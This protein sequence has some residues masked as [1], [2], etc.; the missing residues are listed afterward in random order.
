[1]TPKETELIAKRDAL[2]AA[3]TAFE[4]DANEANEKA[5]IDLTA[6]VERLVDAVEREKLAAA[7][8][9]LKE[10]EVNAPTLNLKKQA[11]FS[12]QKFLLALS[13]PTAR[14]DAGYEFEMSQEAARLSGKST[15]VPVIPWGAIT[16]KAQDTITAPVGGSDLGMSLAQPVSHDDLFTIATTASFLASA[17]G[18]LGVPIYNAPKGEFRVP[19]MVQP[20]VPA[21][22]A[23]DAAVPDSSAR[24]DALEMKPHTLGAICQIN[25]SALID[26]AP[27][28]INVIQDAIWAAVLNALDQALLGA[29]TP[30]ADQPDGLYALLQG[31][32]GD[33]GAFAAPIDLLAA[34]AYVADWN[35]GEPQAMI[36]SNRLQVWARTTAMSASLTATPVLASADDV[37]MKG[38]N[39]VWNGRMSAFDSAGTPA[40]T[41]PAKNNHAMFGPFSTHAMTV[42]FGGGVELQVN[43]F[44][45]SVYGKGAILVRCMTDADILIR[46]AG[47]FGMGFVAA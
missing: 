45:D 10:I 33:F 18:A 2:V 4:A 9:S 41:P 3:T 13:D 30:D 34:L 16:T 1:M 40:P 6:E 22:V 19:R 11:P 14:V 21:W 42:L 36:A 26:T 39:Q 29:P 20:I 7:A 28:M 23:R 44:A 15:S 32:A 43:P 31:T 24:F 17:A 47:R 5:L 27:P 38:L 25:R 37:L 46:D 12:I 35:S 8:A